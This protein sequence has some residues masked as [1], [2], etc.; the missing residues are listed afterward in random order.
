M[1]WF[2]DNLELQEAARDS[3]DYL[4]E[5]GLDINARN[6][7]NQTALHGSVY[8]G[9][10]MLVP[11]LLERGAEIDAINSRGQTPWMIA[12][13]GEYRSGSFYTQ[14]E[15]GAL[16]ERLGADTSLGEDLGVDFRKVLEARGQQQ[17]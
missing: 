3:I 13:E 8:L 11:Y 12:W 17:Q 14:K 2:G 4:L 1:R 16:L 10:T 15:T 7:D 5:L 6:D 9:G